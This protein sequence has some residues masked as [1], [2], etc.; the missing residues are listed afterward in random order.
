MARVYFIGI[1]SLTRYPDQLVALPPDSGVQAPLVYWPCV[2]NT[3]SE[4]VGF[5]LGKGLEAG[6]CC[7]YSLI[8]AD[9]P[10]ISGYS[11]LL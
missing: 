2:F 10:G 5:A 7:Q 4:G 11:L 9:T 3:H 6:L 1:Y 8:G